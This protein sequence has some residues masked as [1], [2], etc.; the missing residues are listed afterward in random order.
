MHSFCGMDCNSNHYI[1][2]AKYRFWIAK[3]RVV[4]S[5]QLSGLILKNSKTKYVGA[6]EEYTLQTLHRFQNDDRIDA[7]WSQLEDATKTSALKT[8]GN[9]SCH[10]RKERFDEECQ[11]VIDEKSAIYKQ[12]Q[13][14]FTRA[15]QGTYVESKCI[16]EIICIK[17]NGK[18]ELEEKK[19]V[20]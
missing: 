18:F 7:M 3:K 5:H 1:I 14:R 9:E 19:Q 16:A 20:G 6:L 13:E 8:I 4:S 11:Q 12:Y 10:K 15:K 17:Q 2:R